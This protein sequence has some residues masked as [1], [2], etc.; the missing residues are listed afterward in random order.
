MLKTP[1]TGDNSSLL[2]RQLLF[3]LGGEMAGAAWFLRRKDAA[4]AAWCAVEQLHP[5]VTVWE[6]MTPY[7]EKEELSW[8]YLIALLV[9]ITGSIIVVADTLIRHHEHEHQH[10]FTHTHDGSTH[11]HTITHTHGHDHYLMG[12]KHRHHHTIAE[13][14][15]ER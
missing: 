8:M 7:F 6:T 15:R 10:T 1:K 3:G 9:M 4:D 13:L 11:E 5:E 12:S 14:E 2:I